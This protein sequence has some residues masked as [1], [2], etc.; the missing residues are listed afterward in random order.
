MINAL[1]IDVE[2]YYQ[3]SAFESLSPPDSWPGFESRVEGNT[4]R[5]LDLLDEAGVKATFFILGWVADKCK[6][7][8]GEISKR[9]HEIASHGY[10]HRRVYTQTRA[11]FREDVRKAKTLLEDQVGMEI[12]GYRAP[13]YSISQESIWAFDELAK[14]GYKYDSSVFPIRHDLYG[15]PFWPRFPF[16]VQRLEGGN[17][18]PSDNSIDKE[19][20]D[21][22]GNAT[23]D[24]ASRLLEIPITTLTLCGRN[25]P[26]AGGGYFRL[27]PYSVTHWGLSRI[28]RAEKK[29][30]IFY[31]HPWEIDPGQPRMK[32]AS[33]KSRFRHY[34]NLSKTE[35]RFK[36]LLRDFKFAPICEAVLADPSMKIDMDRRAS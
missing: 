5:I 25:F 9:N 11:E 16:F 26:L 8:A 33:S 20:C 13:S 1:T 10:W 6:G 17:W 7:L 34:L 35:T 21:P 18:A 29:S 4:L 28:N 19:Y 36:K 30:F 27:F 2:D 12:I 22:E 14:A 3:V 23:N 24:K 31:L 15:M 32:N